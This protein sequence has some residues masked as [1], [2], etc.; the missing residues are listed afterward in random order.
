MKSLHN[1]LKILTSCFPN[2]EGI[3]TKETFFRPAALQVVIRKSLKKLTR[4]LCKIEKKE[5]KENEWEF[6]VAFPRSAS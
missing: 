1:W 6:A 4:V 2:L 5:K 3:E